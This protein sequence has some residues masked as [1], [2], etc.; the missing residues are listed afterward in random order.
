MRAVK[1]RAS[2]KYY[3]REQKETERDGDD[4][5]RNQ[6]LISG[7]VNLSFS[8][9]LAET[10]AIRKWTHLGTDNERANNRSA[11][12]PASCSNFNKNAENRECLEC[13]VSMEAF[14]SGQSYEKSCSRVSFWEIKGVLIQETKGDAQLDEPRDQGSLINFHVPLH[15]LTMWSSPCTTIITASKSYFLSEHHC[16]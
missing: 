3:H 14:I 2:P 5:G 12:K 6:W 4:D 15:F 16:G 11:E 7:I 9:C 13:E 8:Y 10:A 1:Y